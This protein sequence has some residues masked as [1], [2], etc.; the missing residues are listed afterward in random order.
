MSLLA[1]FHVIDDENLG[2][3]LKAARRGTADE[4]LLLLLG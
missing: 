4:V 1:S 2:T 3:L